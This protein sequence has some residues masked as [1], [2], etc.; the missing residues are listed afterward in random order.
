[1]N[2]KFDLAMSIEILYI[3]IIFRMNVSYS[4]ICDHP[5]TIKINGDFDRCLTCGQSF[6][7][8]TYNK[9]RNKTSGDFT[10]ENKRF[11]RNFDR[12]FTNIIEETDYITEPA[13]IEYYTDRMQTNLITVNR[14][15]SLPGYPPKYKI[16]VNGEFEYMELEKIRE[17]LA[18]IDAVKIDEIPYKT[19]EMR[20]RNSQIK[21]D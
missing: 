21:Y 16:T 17:L 14:S 13:H 15:D 9:L 5:R 12:N 10:R 8:S 2:Y 19:L 20:K 6:I 3:D 7:N 18:R 1:M 4:A 11:T